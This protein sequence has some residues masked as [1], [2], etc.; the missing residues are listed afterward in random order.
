MLARTSGVYG[1]AV[2]S[3]PPATASTICGPCATIASRGSVVEC[4]RIIVPT[5]VAASHEMPGGMP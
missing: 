1:F 5:Y 2:R 3:G 4:V